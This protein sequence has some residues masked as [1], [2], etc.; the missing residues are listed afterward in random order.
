MTGGVLPFVTGPHA[1]NFW[2]PGSSL[3]GVP[4][5]QRSCSTALQNIRYSSISVDLEQDLVV[6]TTETWYPGMPSV[7]EYR[8]HL[9]T[10]ACIPHPLA[11]VPEPRG[12][13]E[14]L[15]PPH[16]ANVRSATEI[17]GDLVAWSV[18]TNPGQILVWNWKTGDVLLRITPYAAK[19]CFKFLDESHLL[20]L[21]DQDLR[22]YEFSPLTS[23]SGIQNPPVP[24]AT[25]DNCPCVLRLPP[26][27]HEAVRLLGLTLCLQSPSSGSLIAPLFRHDP[28]LKIV[29]IAL[30]LGS[31]AREDLLNPN[32]E[33]YMFLIP[34]SAL[35]SQFQRARSSS[36]GLENAPLPHDIP[37]EHWGPPSS[38][39]FKTA[40]VPDPGVSG[41]KVT[42]SR[43]LG[44]ESGR[45]RARFLLQVIDINPFAVDGGLGV[46]PPSTAAAPLANPG[47]GGCITDCRFFRGPIRS[48]I[49]YTMAAHEV[50]LE[51]EAGADAQRNSG[52]HE[53]VVF[54]DQWMFVGVVPSRLPRVGADDVCYQLYMERSDP[55]GPTQFTSTGVHTLQI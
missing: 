6:L 55:A 27:A 37:W 31:T 54:E 50:S 28:D 46:D 17:F 33:Q 12:P 40:S 9:L 48:E 8:V 1:L 4:E 7:D 52:G 41:T 21:F 42:M 32:F 25:I 3:R 47:E 53:L 2:K 20:V 43:R 24:P 36:A 39:V 38:R 34:V 13:G 35:L 23:S 19:S 30:R 29:C 26:F 22:I 11:A 18:S 49:P 51:V 15:P 45:R 14:W 5:V 44:W 16:I 10:T